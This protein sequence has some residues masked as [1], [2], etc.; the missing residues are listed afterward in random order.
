[1]G[2]I[3]ISDIPKMPY[4]SGKTLFEDESK[5]EEWFNLLHNRREM[6]ANLIENST[7]SMY[8]KSGGADAEEFIIVSPCTDGIYKY[9]LTKF[10]KYG[11][12]YDIKRNDVMD[13]VK[14]IPG[15]YGVVEV[16]E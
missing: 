1:M 6:L 5:A 15:A 7:A 9:Q 8:A 10:D 4:I 13:I 14:D 3:E 12:V 11:A 2:K 16:M